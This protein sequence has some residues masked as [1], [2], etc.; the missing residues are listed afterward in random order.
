M[1]SNDDNAVIRHTSDYRNPVG[2][3]LTGGESPNYYLDEEFVAG[4]ARRFEGRRQELLARRSEVQARLDAGERPS[5]PTDTGEIRSG[6][7]RGAPIRDDLRDRVVRSLYR[8]GW[9]H[10][11]RIPAP[12]V[13]VVT[14][15]GTGQDGVWRDFVVTERPRL[16]RVRY[17]L[18]FTARVVR[19]SWPGGRLRPITSDFATTT[20]LVRESRRAIRENLRGLPKLSR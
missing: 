3:Q 11:H 2:T 9:R 16:G 19:T 13:A 15:T 10:G 18:R 1:E 6:D 4:L 17:T 8:F 12:L 20:G 7:W 14:G 5:F